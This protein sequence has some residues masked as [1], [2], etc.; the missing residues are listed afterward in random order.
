MSI[1]IEKQLA[2]SNRAVTSEVLC[3]HR[4]KKKMSD[5][6]RVPV[7]QLETSSGTFVLASCQVHCKQKLYVF[8]ANKPV[9]NINLLYSAEQSCNIKTV[10]YCNNQFAQVNRKY[11]KWGV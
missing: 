6:L 1:D 10:Q 11:R 9:L 3:K 4:L 5:I 2:R 8:I 7:E